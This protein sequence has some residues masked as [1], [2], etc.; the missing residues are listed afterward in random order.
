M[1]KPFH[2]REDIQDPVITLLALLHF[3]KSAFI[4][5]ALAVQKSFNAFHYSTILQVLPYTVSSLTASRILLK[6]T[7]KG[8]AT[9]S[10]IDLGISL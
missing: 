10:A 4:S 3:G 7:G 6:I 8:R 9:L 5:K 1:P 2:L